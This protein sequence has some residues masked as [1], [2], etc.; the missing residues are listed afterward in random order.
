LADT[1]PAISSI[2]LV[3]VLRNRYQQDANAMHAGALI[4]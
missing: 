2:I 3:S 1:L 4:W